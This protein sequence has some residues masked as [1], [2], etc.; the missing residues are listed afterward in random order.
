VIV[1][2]IDRYISHR[3]CPIYRAID[4]NRYEY[5]FR[6]S[7]YFEIE[8]IWDFKNCEIS[9]QKYDGKISKF[10]KTYMGI[11]GSYRKMKIGRSHKLEASADDVREPHGLSLKEMIEYIEEESK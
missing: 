1:Q 5:R 3:N 4:K 7:K 6:S 10:E 11:D 2:I 8:S 9:P